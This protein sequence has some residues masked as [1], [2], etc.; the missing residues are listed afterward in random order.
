MV[1]MIIIGVLSMLHASPPDIFQNSIVDKKIEKH[2]LERD[3]YIATTVVEIHSD[4][5]IKIQLDPYVPQDVSIRKIIP[6]SLTAD[7]P[8]NKEFAFHVDEEL[9]LLGFTRRGNTFIRYL[10]FLY[11]PE[12]REVRS[13]IECGQESSDFFLALLYFFSPND[14]TPIESSESR[15]IKLSIFPE[16]KTIICQ[17]KDGSQAT[18]GLNTFWFF[19]YNNLNAFTPSPLEYFENWKSYYQKRAAQD[20]YPASFPLLRARASSPSIASSLPPFLQKNDAT[21]FRHFAICLCCNPYA[22]TFLKSYQKSELTSA[23]T[24]IASLFSFQELLN[25]WRPINRKT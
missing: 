25:V 1:I 5:F 15:G 9:K 6:S 16:P 14:L 4:S 18:Y 11:N 8:I 12:N 3:I 10:P 20:L 13:L 17:F 23:C 24:T 22:E 21:L 19:L 2:L 7:N